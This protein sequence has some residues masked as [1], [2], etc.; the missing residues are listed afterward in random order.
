MRLLAPAF[1][2]TLPPANRAAGSP[3]KPVSVKLTSMV[4]FLIPAYDEEA[5][6]G[7]LLYKIRQVMQGVRRDYL[8]VV[9]DDASRD[10]T[11]ETAA[12]Y[13]KFLPVKVLRHAQNEGFGRCLDRLVRE[14]AR[15]SRYPERDIAITLEADFTWSPDAVPDMVRQIEAGAD[16]VI[17]ARSLPEDRE[18]DMP[19]ARRAGGWISSMVLRVVIPLRGVNDYTSTFRAYRIGILKRAIA[20]NQEGLITARDGAA[21]VE[22][23]LRLGRLHPTVAEVSARCRY[24]IRPRPSRYRWARAVRSELSLTGRVGR[25]A[26]R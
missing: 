3:G 15:L 5:T 13:Q 4:Y 17:G 19:L 6:L 12:K 9:L 23:L 22:L 8:A 14:A 7:L 18:D 25:V 11:P 21:N 10:A 1:K 26:T 2:V 20:A 24:D 16:I